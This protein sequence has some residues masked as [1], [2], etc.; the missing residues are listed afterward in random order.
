MNKI[1]SAL[2]AL[3]IVAGIAAPAFAWTGDTCP[4]TDK[5]MCDVV[6]LTDDTSDD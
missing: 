2:I 4:F 1:V 6:S 3:T 5:S